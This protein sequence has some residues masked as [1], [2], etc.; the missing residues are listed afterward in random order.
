MIRSVMVRFFLG[1]AVLVGAFWLPDMVAKAE[2]V[3]HRAIY[4]L[5]LGDSGS[6]GRF[7]N[8]GG[9]V[10]TTLERTCD[11]W[12][13]AEQI[14]ML[15]E[16]QSGA[17][18]QQNLAYTGWESL[19]GRQYRFAARSSTG[20]EK[21]NYRGQAR[22]HPKNSGE[23]VYT[24]PKKMTQKLPPDT[25]FY[26]GL[27]SWVI[28]KAKAGVSR[29]ETTVFD[30]TDEEGVQRVS[31]FIVPLKGKKAKPEDEKDSGLG[32]LVKR[33]G[34]TIRLAFY[35]VD[36]RGGAPEYEVQADILDNG[37]TPKME[38]IFSDFTAI[39]KLEKIEALK[40]PDC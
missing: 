28:E 35:P 8:V 1:F 31:A 10:R 4:S 19:D 30:G 26:F 29:A 23:A 27:V 14:K 38:L 20:T 15:V 36:S 12:I 3:P 2:I 40:R 21:K 32:P 33:P 16:T 24:K 37:V 13:S 25:H 11:A 17:R 9:G 7:V 39:Q 34:W 18:L 6:S 22:S 5:S